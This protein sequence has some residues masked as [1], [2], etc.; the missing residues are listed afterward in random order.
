M[1]MILNT[2]TYRFHDSPPVL[3]LEPFRSQKPDPRGEP[4]MYMI[5][6][7]KTYGFHYF[8]MFGLRSLVGAK[9]RIREGGQECIGLH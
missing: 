6:I 1:Y 4:D 7:T 9:N 8:P 5:V 3:A 2:K